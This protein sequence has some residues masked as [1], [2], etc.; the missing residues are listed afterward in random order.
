MLEAQL[1]VMPNAGN[2]LRPPSPTPAQNPLED[3]SFTIVLELNDDDQPAASEGSVSE[4]EFEGLSSLTPSKDPPPWVPAVTSHT[5]SAA[6]ESAETHLVRAVNTGIIDASPHLIK[7]TIKPPAETFHRSLWSFRSPRLSLDCWKRN[8]E[9]R[10]R[11]RGRPKRGKR[12]C[13]KRRVHVV[14]CHCHSRSRS[15]KHELTPV[16]LARNRDDPRAQRL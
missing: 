10:E 13:C 8:R 4:L 7:S 15:G 12:E 1:G 5:T 11:D 16:D 3:L 6:S 14:V 2:S 9:L